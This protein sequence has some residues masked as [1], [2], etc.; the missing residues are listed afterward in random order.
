MGNRGMKFGIYIAKDQTAK[1]EVFARRT[2]TRGPV[3]ALAETPDGDNK[4]SIIN[5]KGPEE[6]IDGE[7]IGSFTPGSTRFARAA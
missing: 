1:G 3:D 4:A 6:A 2:K 5:F 7:L